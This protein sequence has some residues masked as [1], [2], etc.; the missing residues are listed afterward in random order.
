M[1]DEA[2]NADA[3]KY[4][5]MVII[6]PELGSAA[7]KK[8]LEKVKKLVADVKGTIFYEDDWGIRDLAYTIKKRDKGYYAVYDF[9]GIDVNLKELDD[10]L[11]LDNE[12]LRHLVVK[13]PFAYETKSYAVLEEEKPKEEKK[14]PTKAEKA[15]PAP[16]AEPKEEPAPEPEV[17]EE[18][19]E[20][21][22]AE[23]AAE[24][25]A[26]EPP[27]EEAPAEEKAPEE[28]EAEEEKKEDK[29][30]TLEEVDE[31]L[32]NIIDNPDLNF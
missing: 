11:K 15:E 1:S 24:V 14:K 21:A 29:K 31:K 18:P 25:P 4:E 20:E 32:K 2:S 3:T 17:K 19:V 7:I 5:L 6:D 22:P 27:V 23:A 30:S 28:P 16:V 26:E 12:V 8:S 10:T 9:E 13:L